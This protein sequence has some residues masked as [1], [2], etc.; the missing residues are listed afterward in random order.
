MRAI[1]SL[2]NQDIS[3]LHIRIFPPDIRQ[4]ASAPAKV[5]AVG[6]SDDGQRTTRNIS[7]KVAT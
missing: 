6:N 2:S 5:R 3:A 1:R 4:S 7:S